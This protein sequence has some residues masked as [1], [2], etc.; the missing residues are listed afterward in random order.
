L[1]GLVTGA[2]GA[3]WGPVVKERFD[4]RHKAAEVRDRYSP[5]LLQAAYDLQSRFYNIVRQAFLQTY[6]RR[7]DERRRYAEFSTLWLLGQY[8]GWVEILRRE[9]QFLD[10]GTQKKNRAL[11][12]ALGK[13][14]SELA[15]DA[16][17][18][19]FAVFRT[20]QRAIGELMIEEGDASDASKRTASL[21]YAEF[22]Q[23]LE[24]PSF[25][26]WFSQLREDL[27]AISAKRDYKRLVHV[28]RALVDLVDELDSE[29][30]RYP[31]L[32]QRGK[33]PLATCEA[34]RPQRHGCSRIARFV[35]RPRE[36]GEDKENFPRRLLDEWA[37][38]H[39]LE[40]HQTTE[41]NWWTYG[42]KR[43]PFSAR[44]V[45]HA[46]YRPPTLEI[47]AA[48]APPRWARLSRFA[49]SHVPLEAGG[50]RFRR[51]RRRAR[52][53]AND[54]LQRLGRPSLL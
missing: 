25:A 7:D 8:L 22:V 45:L 51:S 11:Q 52:R 40:R 44:L 34:A 26:Q 10:F 21:G 35:A 20:A 24:E 1:G 33:L 14:S 39:A 47:Y 32:D 36:Y 37:E 31:V 54:L 4:R 28:Q 2:A 27:T 6:M 53:I 15:R 30:I 46:F 29:R 12:E 19:R 5:P 48:A 3:L 17:G 13:V 42:A 49:P 16:Y 38:R 50:W 23:R 18:G 43:P 9:V 41:S